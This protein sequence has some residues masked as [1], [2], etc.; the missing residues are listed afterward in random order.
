MAEIIIYG[1]ELGDKN[2]KK[3]KYSLITL[4]TI[5]THKMH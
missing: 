4:K 1:E 3:Y 5:L 2:E